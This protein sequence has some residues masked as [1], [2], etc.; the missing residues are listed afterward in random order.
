MSLIRRYRGYILLSLAWLVALGGVIF[1]A[2]QPKP[3]PLEILPPPPRPTSAP[4]APPQPLQVYVTGAVHIPDVYE[5]APDSR[6]EDAIAAAGGATEE[7]D[8]E[9]INQAAP[10]SD[11]AH[12]HVPSLADHLPTPPPI[13]TS[14]LQTLLSSPSTAAGSVD[15][16]TATAED[17]QTMP[18][19]GPALAQRIIEQRPY[20]SIEDVMR[21]SGIGEA[22][23]EKLKDLI[24]VQ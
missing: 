9:A 11:G 14:T 8:V 23:F 17:L 22:T 20:G 5:L 1:G 24:T 6:V 21:V 2:C 3:S 18:G 19:I 16:N 13:S 15:I 4:T 10:L 7:A 12:I